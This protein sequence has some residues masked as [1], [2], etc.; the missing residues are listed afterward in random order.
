MLSI[1]WP[2]GEAPEID[3]NMKSCVNVFRVLF[4]YLSGENKYLQNLQ[5]NGSYLII[6]DGAEPGVYEYIDNSGNIV[7]KKI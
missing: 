4:S 7:F 5:K 3:S 6:K 1:R 2:N